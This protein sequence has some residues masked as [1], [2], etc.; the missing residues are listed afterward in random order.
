MIDW[1]KYKL[2]DGVID[3]FAAIKDNIENFDKLPKEDQSF[4][5]SLVQEV[6]YLQPIRKP[7]IAAVALVMIRQNIVLAQVIGEVLGQMGVNLKSP[8]EIQAEKNRAAI[9]IVSSMPKKKT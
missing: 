3:L 8:E 6:E 1:N 7:E 9:K 5:E 2:E 4:A